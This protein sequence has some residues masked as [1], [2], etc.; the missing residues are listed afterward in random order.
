MFKPNKKNS[1]GRFEVTHPKAFHV[2]TYAGLIGEI[3]YNRP[4]SKTDDRRKEVG[5]IGEEI[6]A[7]YL[8]GRGFKIIQ[9]NYRK[10][11]GEIDI[12]AESKGVV[13]FV[14]VKSVSRETLGDISRENSD[15]R[16]E[17]MAHP[18]KLHKVA[19]TAE[20]YM[21]STNDSRE[22]QIDVVGVLLDTRTRK[23]RCRLFEQV[24]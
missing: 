9:R 1:K 19:R 6:A 8:Q 24:M 10:P 17:E 16:P 20:M 2:K 14:E 15:Y 22:Y 12:I 4:V 3:D 18:A 23:A 21:N 13:R 7:R 5:R 11:W